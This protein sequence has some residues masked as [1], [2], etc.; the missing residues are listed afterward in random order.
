[1]AQVVIKGIRRPPLSGKLLVQ[2]VSAS[3]LYSENTKLCES[4][5]K[6]TSRGVEYLTRN[7]PESNDPIWSE[8]PFDLGFF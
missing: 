3:H 7:V 4:F 2:V 1:M 5:A 6:V 8:T